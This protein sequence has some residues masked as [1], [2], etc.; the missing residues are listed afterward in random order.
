MEMS[1]RTCR[2][3]ALRLIFCE[4]FFQAIQG[5]FHLARLPLCLSLAERQQRRCFPTSSGAG[6][7]DA[8]SWMEPISFWWRAAGM[9]S[10]L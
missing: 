1:W 6:Q 4:Y 7:G 5:G 8:A 9:M 3:C 2:G 10:S